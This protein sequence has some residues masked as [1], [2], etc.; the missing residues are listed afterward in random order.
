MVHLAVRV[1]SQK[2]LEKM[3]FGTLVP[4]STGV[5]MPPFRSPFS[6]FALRAVSVRQLL[7]ERTESG[8][9]T[10]GIGLVLTCSL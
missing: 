5:D 3:G 8:R 6:R 7:P 1:Q 4:V 9:I 10:V 2:L